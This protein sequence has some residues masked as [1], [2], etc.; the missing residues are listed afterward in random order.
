MCCCKLDLSL[1]TGFKLWNSLHN[2]FGKDCTYHIVPSIRDCT[3]CYVFG[4]MGVIIAVT[5]TK[6]KS[7]KIVCQNN[8]LSLN[9]LTR[10]KL[11]TVRL[12]SVLFRTNNHQRN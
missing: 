4:L 3:G 10:D 9:D 2:Y 1:L 6:A 5:N 11:E 12:L 8:V 7:S